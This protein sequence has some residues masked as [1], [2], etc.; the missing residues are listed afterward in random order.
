MENEKK[1]RRKARS[2]AGF[3]KQ[4][5]LDEVAAGYVEAFSRPRQDPIVNENRTGRH[6]FRPGYV[7]AHEVGRKGLRGDSEFDSPLGWPHPRFMC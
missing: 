7:T 2:K 4:E 5:V 3:D 6:C 1:P